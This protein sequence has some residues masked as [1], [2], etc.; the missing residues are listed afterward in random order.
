MVNLDV[1]V[2]VRFMNMMMKIIEIVGFFFSFLIW[3]KRFFKFLFWE[4]FVYGVIWFREVVVKKIF[5]I[6]F[7]IVKEFRVME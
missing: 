7:I 3:E 5:Y 6:S 4:R 2:E 1:D